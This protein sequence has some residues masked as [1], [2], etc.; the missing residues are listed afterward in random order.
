MLKDYVN[1]PQA[2]LTSSSS[3]GFNPVPSFHTRTSESA[4]KR[5]IKGDEDVE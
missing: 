2:L 1:K 3:R 4:A 5:R